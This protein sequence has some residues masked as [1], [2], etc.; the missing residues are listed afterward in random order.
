MEINMTPKE[1]SKS[2]ASNFTMLF[3]QLQDA[4][5]MERGRNPVLRSMI[6]DA[7]A[8][9]IAVM[10]YLKTVIEPEDRNNDLSYVKLEGIRDAMRNLWMEER[11][12]EMKAKRRA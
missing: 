12:L 1:Q 7:T 2:L 11:D 3:I 5:A 10:E 4:V 6:G 8:D 9:I